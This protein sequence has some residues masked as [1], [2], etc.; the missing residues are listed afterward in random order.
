MNQ[1]FPSERLQEIHRHRLEASSDMCWGIWAND[2]I[3]LPAHLHESYMK[4]GPLHPQHIYFVQCLHEQ[5]LD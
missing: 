4:R 1:E 3:R 5:K 2:I